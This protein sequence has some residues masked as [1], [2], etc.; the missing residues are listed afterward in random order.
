DC[1]CYVTEDLVDHINRLANSGA[2]L[3]MSDIPG[4]GIGGLDHVYIALKEQYPGKYDLLPFTCLVD[5]ERLKMILPEGEDIHQPEEMRFLLNAQLAEA[6]LIVLNKTD[7]LT[8]EEIAFD[9]DFIQK[10]YP[11]IPVM[12]MSARTGEGVEEVVDYILSHRSPAEHRDIGYGSDEFNAAEEKM[13]WYNRRFFARQRDER[14]IDFNQVIE[15]YME[16]IRD[17]L[18]EAKRNVGHLKLFVAGEG[19]D[20]LKVSLIGVDY[21]LEW[22]RKLD[23]PYAAM[24]VVVNVRAMCESETMAEVMEDA[25]D[26]I[27]AEYGLK[28]NVIFTEC[29]GFADEGRRNG[30]RASRYE[31]SGLE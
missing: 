5:P 25:M 21:D 18:I 12:T 24:S 17:G 2:D 27:K 3:V 6:D 7:V 29:F 23:K 30:G 11:E 28:C 8:P 15:D 14:N 9:V 22:E 4:C 19:N 1:I 16:A 10:A 26:A 13:C 31:G 20:F